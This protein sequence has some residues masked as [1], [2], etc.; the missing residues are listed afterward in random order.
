[1]KILSDLNEQRK[2]K[3]VDLVF[4]RKKKK[5]SQALFYMN[6]RVHIREKPQ[7]RSCGNSRGHT[8]S[9]FCLRG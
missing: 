6:S 4:K 9:C 2:K 5:R 3:T 7:I 1:M 8:P